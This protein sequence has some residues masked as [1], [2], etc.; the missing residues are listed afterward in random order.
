[1][2]AGELCTRSQESFLDGCVARSYM[3]LAWSL[4]IKVLTG[5]HGRCIVAHDEPGLGDWSQCNVVRRSR[6]SH[7]RRDPPWFDGIREDG[8]PTPSYGESEHDVE[9]F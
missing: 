5:H 3:C 2:D 6:S 7:F 9:Q 4:M 1:M 8:C